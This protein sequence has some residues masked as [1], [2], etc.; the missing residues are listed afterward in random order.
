MKKNLAFIYIFIL[1]FSLTFV[2]VFLFSDFFEKFTGRV[3]DNSDQP[4]CSRIG[5]RSEGWY[6][7]EGFIKWDNCADCEAVCLYEGTENEGWYSSCENRLIKLEDCDKVCL[8]TCSS[9]GYKCGIQNICDKEIDCGNCQ[10]SYECKEGVCELLSFEETKKVILGEDYNLWEDHPV[11]YLQGT[12]EVLDLSDE[13]GKFFDIKTDTKENDIEFEIYKGVIDPKDNNMWYDQ[14]GVELYLSS[15]RMTNPSLEFKIPSG[16]KYSILYLSRP[17][18]DNV[19]EDLIIE[20]TIFFT[21]SSI[22]KPRNCS[23]ASGPLNALSVV[24]DF[25]DR[26]L[27][28]YT[29][30]GVNSISN[31]RNI[32][33]KMES[34][35]KWLSVGVELA[36]WDIIRIT[37]PKDFTKDA[38]SDGYS[39]RNEIVTLVQQQV[40]DE[41]YDNDCDGQIDNIFAVISSGENV[42]SN[43]DYDYI[44]AGSAYN[45]KGVRIFMDPQGSESV[46]N[47]VYGNFN[48][49]FGH[50]H[51]V[52]NN[53]WGLPDFYGSYD[54]LGYLTLMSDSWSLPANGFS[55]YDRYLLEWIEPEGIFS[56]TQ[57][58]LLHSAEENLDAIKILTD[59]PKEF[60]LVEYKK[61]PD[62]GYGSAEFIPDYNGLVIYHVYEEVFW[63]YCNDGFPPLLYVE[64]ADGEIEYASGGPKKTDYWYPDNEDSEGIFYAKKWNSNEVIFTLENLRW[65]GEGIM[66]DIIFNED[67]KKS[68][69]KTKLYNESTQKKT[70]CQDGCFL[71]NQCYEFGY[72]KSGKFCSENGYFTNQF[73]E[74]GHCENNFECESNFCID[75]NCISGS[76]IQRILNW[77]RKLFQGE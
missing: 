10:G 50:G 1:I 11:W 56:T 67:V 59:N 49:E 25:Q 19:P 69:D 38:Y 9:L 6:N 44:T 31:L 2:S 18:E 15:A 7:S 36:P 29:G 72:R 58:I 42:A 20:R 21:D 48:H 35:W 4:Y 71:N 34:H 43:S 5:T 51:P 64:P 27:E 54:T 40:N 47:E 17:K 45:N 46:R 52:R 12:I 53:F 22:P 30:E 57:D 16:A 63:D 66:F 28:D 41:L 61:K 8:D 55:A 73:K 60:F 14:E 13:E 24:V 77:F 62:L 32:L 37:L 68:L 75:G 23:S 26:K 39:F 3:V 70:F 33:D 65:F 74:E 76:L